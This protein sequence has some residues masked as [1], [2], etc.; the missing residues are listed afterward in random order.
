MMDIFG[1]APNPDSVGDTPRG[2]EQGASIPGAVP[3][4]D[5]SH[6]E[7]EAAVE[8]N[9]WDGYDAPRPDPLREKRKGEDR[10]FCPQHG[11][12]CSPG[13]CTA[14]ARV[15][16]D[17]RWQK[18]R[19]EREENKRRWK[20]RRGRRPRRRPDGQEAPR[21]DQPAHLA[22]GPRGASSTRGSGSE[23]EGSFD[24]GAMLFERASEMN[25]YLTRI[26]ILTRFVA[27]PY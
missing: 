2:T 25:I 1:A 21:G 18:E 27:H 12:L 10:W 16:R 4:Q 24:Q 20:E 13:I 23:A 15:E 9:P 17:E 3:V 5:Q 26:G 22:N 8:D 6:V 14:R 19:E 7:G 11:P